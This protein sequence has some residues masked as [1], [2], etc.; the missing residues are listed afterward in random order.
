M[1]AGTNDCL[2]PREELQYLAQIIK[3]TMQ[4]YLNGAGHLL[5]H[6]NYPSAARAVLLAL[7]KIESRLQGAEEGGL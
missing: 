7:E 6:E 3:P 1:I 5:H 4:I 2:A